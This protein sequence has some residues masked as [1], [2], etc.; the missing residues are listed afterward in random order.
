MKVVWI[1]LSVVIVL[2]GGLLCI[3][4]GAQ[5]DGQ[6]KTNAMGA[7]AGQIFGLPIIGT[8]VASLF[9]R[10]RNLLTLSRNFFFICL[11]MVV[12]ALMAR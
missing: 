1:V 9:K 3:G 12:L 7:M 2:F 8:I 4:A 10:H 6:Q 5:L 11:L